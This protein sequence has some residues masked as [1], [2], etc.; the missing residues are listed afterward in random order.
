[1]SLFRNVN[2]VFDICQIYFRIAWEKCQA[3]IIS[4]DEIKV[5]NSYLD[6]KNMQKNIYE[7]LSH[8]KLLRK[9]ND[10][11]VKLKK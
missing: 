2:K 6:L 9:W 11:R 10:K 3:G 5:L 1:M 7:I 8:I 4:R